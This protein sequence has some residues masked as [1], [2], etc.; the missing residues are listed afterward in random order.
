M[1]NLN[2]KFHF[3][4]VLF[5]W[6]IFYPFILSGQNKID[7]LSP[8]NK[9]A[10][11]TQVFCNRPLLNNCNQIENNSFNTT[12]FGDN[13]FALNC[14]SGWNSMSYSPQLNLFNP[15]FAPG[16]NHASMWSYAFRP[17]VILGEGIVT[18][19]STLVA[20]N[21]YG[22]SIFKR[23]FPDPS[24]P[25]IDL[26][27]FYIVLLKCSDYLAIRTDQTDVPAIPRNAQII[28]CET[29]MNNN[30]FQRVFQTFTANDNYDVAWIF[31]KQTFYSD[32][33]AYQAWL[34]VAKFEMININNFSAGPTPNPTYLNCNVTLG[35]SI[36][37]CGVEGAVFTWYGPNGQVVLASTDNQ[38]IQ[39]DAGNSANTGSWTL[40]M[41]VPNVV[42]TNNTC[43]GPGIVQASVNV[44][45]CV[46]CAAQISGKF[47]GC[48]ITKPIIPYALNYYCWRGDCGS[49]TF[50][51]SN[52]ASG[53]EWFVNDMQIIGTGGNIPGIGF[54]NITNNTKNLSF[55]IS[56]ST[57]TQSFKFQVKNTT[58]G[59]TQI[60][61]PTTVYAAV[62]P[63]PYMGDYKPNFT[64][65][66]YTYPYNSAGPGSIYTWS[67]PNTII[68]DIDPSTPEATIYF[69]PNV[70]TG[71][72]TGTITI[73]N[74]PYCNG[75]Y[76]IT[77]QQN[78]NARSPISFN[79]EIT[80]P[81]YTTTFPNP[82]SNQI[83][84]T[85]VE[86]INYI[87][88]SDLLNPTFKRVKVNSTK[89]VTLDVSDLVPGVY[90]CK[91]STA[92][93]IEN[94][95]LIIKR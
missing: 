13:P 55:G 49:S 58:P 93:G 35:P 12:C 87:E 6:T 22:F 39:V 68:T 82:A 47:E 80:N 40:K 3:L 11:P 69:P 44:P 89:S 66:Y 50:L 27:N 71:G 4:I 37:N 91:I 30:S 41:T 56:A 81:K 59:C 85:S 18:G 92:K 94:Q 36:P 64:K 77:F 51:E 29:H 15:L 25:S 19:I 9:F 28:Y 83:T 95:K 52:Y 61:L 42:T 38:Q 1:K 67:V 70:S 65:T 33:R 84:I 46:S 14:I 57:A 32:V 2:P 20:G 54:V 74:S 31:P 76:N 10:K 26:D 24:H 86:S 16:V 60:T 7:S 73:S 34:E 75:T 5:L 78:P 72:L 45:S 90:N 79:N 17:G 23:Y 48:A 88:I 53:N 62:L 21:K 8:I 43:S 63:G